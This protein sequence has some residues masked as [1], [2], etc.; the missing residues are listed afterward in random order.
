LDGDDV[1]NNNKAVNQYGTSVKEQLYQLEKLFN[2]E[3][4]HLRALI[5]HEKELRISYEKSVEKALEL[6]AKEVERRLEGMNEL[7]Q[8]VVSDRAQFV[9]REIYDTRQD[10]LDARV[11]AAEKLAA[12]AAATLVGKAQGISTAQLWLGFVVIASVII[13]VV[14]A[15]IGA[16]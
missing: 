13:A 15:V 9:R 8:Q 12:T 3:L 1:P 11:T 10:A 4:H 7:R 16:R 2:S 5:E 14:G 6:R